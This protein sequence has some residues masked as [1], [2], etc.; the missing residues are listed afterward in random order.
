MNLILNIE[1]HLYISAPN[2]VWVGMTALSTNCWA[3][4]S[5][6]EIV[7]HRGLFVERAV[8]FG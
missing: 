4:V 6:L 5:W 1:S 8:L 2:D 7:W 3:S